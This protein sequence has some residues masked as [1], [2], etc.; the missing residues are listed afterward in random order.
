MLFI[1]QK[2]EREGPTSQL[3]PC[4][5]RQQR[6]SN[7]QLQEHQLSQQWEHDNLSFALVFCYSRSR[8]KLN[9]RVGLKWGKEVHMLGFV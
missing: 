5:N 1:Y 7:V 9:K 4:M 2:D 3:V 6:K 8:T